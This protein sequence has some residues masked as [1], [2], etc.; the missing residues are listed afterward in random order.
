MGSFSGT[1][2]STPLIEKIKKSLRLEDKQVGD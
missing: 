1:V 2:M